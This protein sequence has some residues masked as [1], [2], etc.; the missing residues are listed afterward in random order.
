MADNRRPTTGNVDYH[1]LT[2]IIARLASNKKKIVIPI[3]FAIEDSSVTPTS[4]CDS[5]HRLPLPF[6]SPMNSNLLLNLWKT[7]YYSLKAMTEMCK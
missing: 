2:S 5:Y 7:G 6:S 4:P 3:Y 1:K